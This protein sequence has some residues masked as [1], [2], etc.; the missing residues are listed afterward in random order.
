MTITTEIL[1]ALDARWREADDELD[2]LARAER[3]E[4]PQAHARLEARTRQ[5]W[6]KARG[7]YW[8]ACDNAPLEALVAHAEHTADRL[9]QINGGPCNDTY[10][11]REALEG[12]RR[13]MKGR[14]RKEALVEAL[15]AAWY[16]CGA[17]VF[18]KQL[19]AARAA[20][21]PARG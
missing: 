8:A 1:D 17:A 10:Y 2:Y 19:E 13:V 15:A 7:A 18:G 21:E 12:V 3:G 6:L 11:M 4:Q 5:R 20:L 9:E 14:R 16:E